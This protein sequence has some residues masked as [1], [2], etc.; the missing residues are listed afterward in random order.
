MAGQGAGTGI[1]P[2]DEVPANAADP[3]GGGRDDYV[4]AR[5]SC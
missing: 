3:S 1:G 2:V 4:G 5:A